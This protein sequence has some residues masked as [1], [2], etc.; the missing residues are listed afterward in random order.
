MQICRKKKF[1]IECKPLLARSILKVLA[2]HFIDVRLS[3][4]LMFV[5]SI[6]SYFTILISSFSLS[7]LHNPVKISADKSELGEGGA[8]AERGSVQ[9][10]QHCWQDCRST[11]TTPLIRLQLLQK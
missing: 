7:L 9:L 3:D 5:F 10:D 11:G 4:T 2:V 1:D 8:A 6:L